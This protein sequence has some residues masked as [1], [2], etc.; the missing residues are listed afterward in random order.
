MR[1]AERIARACLERIEEREAAVGAWAFLDPQIVL[2]Q[3]RALDASE[4]RGPLHGVPVGIKDII[5]TVDMPTQ[6]GSPVYAGHRPAWDA[7]C[8]AA[9]RAAGGVVMGKTVTTEFAASYPGKT[10][11]PHNLAHTPGGSSSGSAAAV[12]DGM[13]PVALGTQTGGSVIRPASFCGV[14]GYKPT[15]GLISCH[16]IKPLAESLDTVGVF[17]RSVKEAGLLAGVIA[18]R[19]E[20]VNLAPSLAPRIGVWHT[21]EWHE[22]SRDSVA[23][24]ENAARL[25]A[26]AGA[27]VR[28]AG[29]PQALSAIDDAHHAIERFEMVDSLAYEMHCHRDRLS[30][31]LRERVEEGERIAVDDYDQARRTARL[32]RELMHGVFKEFDVLLVPSAT[33]E[34]PKGLESTGSAVFN[35]GWT[36]LQLPCITVPGFHG[37]QGL[38]VGVQLVGASREDARLLAFARWVER[39]LTRL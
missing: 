27:E 11:N 10:R 35:R 36:L 9:I 15:F 12:A 18:R 8:V 28:E 17:A 25:A 13:V 16:G 6:Y 7:A 26:A 4:R 5:A 23:A 33:G 29:M 22:A 38:P 19:P 2:E 3:A 34:A 24:I 14:V 32:C 37:S 20:L 30:Q 21:F 1:N 39:V 31:K